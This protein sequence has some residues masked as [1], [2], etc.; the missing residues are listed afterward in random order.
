M[1]AGRGF[2]LFNLFNLPSW[3]AGDFCDP[4][5]GGR[6]NCMATGIRFADRTIT[7]SP[8]YA[9]QIEYACDGLEK[10]LRNVIGISNAIGKDF[11][12]NINR[13][14]ERSGFLERNYG[15]LM[16]RIKESSGLREK[17][18]S[19]FPEILQGP[20]PPNPLIIPSADQW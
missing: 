6:L 14:F 8:S 7:V 18:E 13:R 17:L 16:E 20:S 12:R 5:F 3:R 10:I 9:G 11:R 2:D 1:T 15:M 19:R 4:V